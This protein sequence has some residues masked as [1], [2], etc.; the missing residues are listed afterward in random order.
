M[1]HNEFESSQ[2]FNIDVRKVVLEIFLGKNAPVF[3]LPHQ[4]FEGGAQQ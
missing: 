3:Q 1:G 2:Q 4:P